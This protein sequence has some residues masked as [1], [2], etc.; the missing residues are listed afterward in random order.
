M[1]LNYIDI[2]L[3]LLILLNVAWGWR[4][5]LILGLIDLVRWVG[6]L[7]LALRFYPGLTR[8][9]D[10]HFSLPQFL[11]APV[12]FLLI[13]IITSTL[14]QAVGLFFARRLPPGIH[15][16]FINRLLGLVPGLING[17][18]AAAI[19]APIL[20]AIPMPEGMRGQTRESQVANRLAII[21]QRLET[22]LSPVFDEAIRNSLN[23]LTVRPEPDSN[24]TVE[25]HFNVENPRPR[26]DLE[27]Q[28]LA[29][30][31]EERVKAGLKPLAPDP[32][33]TMVARQHST[34]MFKRGYF[35]HYTPE[36]LSPFDRMKRANV[37]FLSAGENLAL[38]PTLPIAHTGL[39]NS[40]GHRAN[41]L[42]PQ[43]GRLGI[44]V[45]D[46]GARGLMISQEFRN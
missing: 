28:M 25:L 5:G 27:A 1:N 46:G 15:N 9:I 44:G 41:I 26:P 13:A 31:N 10:T 29:L 14:I 16:N 38:A 35:S 2:L 3:G 22:S 6:S 43:F 23:L 39:M 8:Y 20:L 45:M 4:R 33:L 36:G 7:L 17:V 30:V 18:I 24:E 34:D 32:E 11:S 19:L 40:P 37:T 21:T 12:A 42:R